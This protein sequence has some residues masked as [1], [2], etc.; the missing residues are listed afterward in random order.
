MPKLED[1]LQALRLRGLTDRDK[2]KMWHNV[3]QARTTHLSYSWSMKRILASALAVTF[4]FGS[5]G[6]VSASNGATPG[7]ML[8]PLDLALE[9]AQ[10]ALAGDDKAQTLT[11]AFAE[12]RVDE[13]RSLVSDLSQATVTNIEVDVFTNET[14]VDIEANDKHFI[15]TTALTTQSEIVAEI[16]AKYSIPTD[17]ISAVLDFQIEDRASRPEDKTVTSTASTSVSDDSAAVTTA[18]KNLAKGVTELETLLAGL[19]DQERAQEV[20]QS[21]IDIMIL[22][23]DDAKL[24]LRSD[25]GRIKLENKDG[26][27]RIKIDDRSGSSNDDNDDDRSSG[28]R[29]G[30]DDDDDNDNATPS[31]TT[32]VRENDNE[33]FCRGEWRDPQ[34]CDN[35]SGGN[36]D[37]DDSSGSRG[38]DDDDDDNS[39]DDNDNATPSTTTDVREDDDEVFCRGEWRDAE[40]CDEDS[41]DDEDEDRDDDD[42]D[43]DNDK[44]DDDDNSGSGS[45]GSSNSGSGS[46][47]SSGSSSSGSLTKYTVAQVSTHTSA[48]DCWS[49]VNGGVYNLTSWISSHPG[50]ESAILGMCGEDSSSTFNSIHGS[51]SK[52]NAA[53][54]SYKIG[55]L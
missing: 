52:A 43:D 38:G 20:R 50:G 44:D 14:V 13:I 10:L 1:Q 34:D 41:S 5:V 16:N 22:L 4:I 31:T 28:S 45:S 48:S 9:K 35:G 18:D 15:Y 30:D 39:R 37:D 49:I 2:A 23:G 8:F 46:S 6:A 32:D 3:I 55:T 29:G 12:E 47:G 7:D 53:L 24:E 17:K 40:D 27:V 36:D 51:S 26:E 11:L 21:L 19:R 54:A 42:K 33:V 25:S